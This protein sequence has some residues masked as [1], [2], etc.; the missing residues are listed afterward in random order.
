MNE[1]H[2]DSIPL[3]SVGLPS[4]ETA[5]GFCSAWKSFTCSSWG[6]KRMPLWPGVVGALLDELRPTGS[7]ITVM[8]ARGGVCFVL[9]DDLR[10][11]PDLFVRATLFVRPQQQQREH[12]HMASDKL[13][14]RVAMATGFCRGVNGVTSLKPALAGMGVDCSGER[15]AGKC[16]P[17]T[18]RGEM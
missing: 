9:I 17:R 12:G 2:P 4:R 5:R 3:V 8:E 11:S 6:W 14:N 16:W 15:M 10:G 13:R 18:C 1:G 7:V